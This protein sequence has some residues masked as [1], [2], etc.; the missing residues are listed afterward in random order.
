MPI[1]TKDIAV[2]GRDYKLS[3]LGAVEGSRYWVALLRV[4]G[5][6]VQALSAAKTYDSEAVIAAVTAVVGHLDDDTHDKIARA[7]RA[8]TRVRVGE[9]YAELADDAVFDDCFACNYLAYTQWLG[10]CVLFNYASFLGDIS[11]GKMLAN[12]QSAVLK[13]AS[14]KDST[15]SSGASSA[16]SEPQ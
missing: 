16:T 4:I 13:S 14:P 6:A 12:A 7:F 3:S 8:R 11:I 9:R 5:P 10:E 15:G 2:G 1:R